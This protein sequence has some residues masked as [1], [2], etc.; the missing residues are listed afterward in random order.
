MRPLYYI[1]DAE[2]EPKPAE[3]LEWAKWFED[4]ANRQLARTEVKPD[5]TVSTI[6]LGLD[7]NFCSGKPVLWETVIFGGPRSEEMYRYTNEV[8]ALKKHA[9]IVEELRED[10]ESDDG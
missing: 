9:K 8:A 10:L 1:L 6:F 3:L 7:H 2:G 5:V 4:A